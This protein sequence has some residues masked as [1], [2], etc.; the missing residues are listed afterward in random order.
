MPNATATYTLKFIADTN[1]AKK[2]LNDLKQA[3]DNAFTSNKIGDKMISPEAIKQAAEL[4]GIIEQ[5]KDSAGNFDLSK[6]TNGLKNA[7][8]PLEQVGSILHNIGADNAFD[9]LSQQVLS[10]DANTRILRGTVKKFF[11]GLKNTAM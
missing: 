4:R 8:I 7:K 6:F 3:F 5:A 2:N 11:D 1:E 10:A 9:L